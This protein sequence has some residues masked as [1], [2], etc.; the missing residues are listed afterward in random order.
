MSEIKT[1]NAMLNPLYRYAGGRRD[2]ELE[3]SVVRTLIG[4]ALAFYF[5]HHSSF[6]LHSTLHLSANFKLVIIL[7]LSVAV[8]I[9][10]C[11]ALYPGDVPLRRLIA[12]FVDV[13]TL[14]Y[15]F[16]QAE[17][18][19]APLYFFYLWIII[20]YGFRFGKKY[21]FIS[22]AMSL[23][24]YGLVILTIPYWLMQ[25]SLSLGLWV[26]MLLISLYL[27]TLVGRLYKALDHAEVANRAKRQFISSVS[28]EL[29]TPL[30]AIIGMVDLLKSTGVDREQQDML[31][32]MSTTSQVMLSQI[33]DVL[34]FSKIEAGKMAVEQ[35]DFDLHRLVLGTVDIFRYHVDPLAIEFLISIA[36]DVPYSLRGDPHH[37][38]QILVNLLANAVKFTEQGRI[39]IRI[40]K[41]DHTESGVRL[42]FA[43]KDTGVG[44]PL[45]AQS[46]IF[47]S[48]TQADESTARRYGGTGLGTTICK[49][50]VE[51]M[52]G[53]IGFSSEQGAGSEF[54]FELEMNL[55]P[56]STQDTLS[57]KPRA[58]RSL[59]IGADSKCMPLVADLLEHCCAPVQLEED[60]NAALSKLEQTFLSGK[61]VR[62][63]F[64]N[65]SFPQTEGEM[66]E[67]REKLRA[68]VLASRAAASD[69]P[70]SLILLVPEGIAEEVADELAE[71]AGFS[72][73]LPLPIDRPSLQNILHSHALMLDADVANKAVSVPA[74]DLNSLGAI[75]LKRRSDLSSYHIL[76]AEDNP[77]NR[78]VLQKIL[79]RA[80]HRCTL[81]KDGEEA[82]D[83]IEKKE[84]DAIVLDMN[85]PVMTGLE[86]ARTYCIMR[87]PLTRAPMIMF[88]ANVTLEA[89]EES[90]NAGVDEFMPKPIQIE[91]FI[92]TLDRLV[93]HYKSSSYLLPEKP[94]LPKKRRLK[95]LFSEEPNL[96]VQTLDDL[97]KIS[98]DPHFLDDLILEFIAENRKIMIRFE[99]AL[100]HLKF[101][102]IKEI[103]HALKGSAVSIGAVSLKMLCKRIEKMTK[104]DQEIY[105]SEILQAIKQVCYV[106]CEELEAYRQQRNQYLSEKI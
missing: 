54:W 86:V 22:L 41:L 89:K 87:G 101:E 93:S 14:T 98:R 39:T 6:H 82:L 36:C 77:T 51:L 59:M 49:Q 21:L 12:I 81:A 103:L 15:L 10:V 4:I 27:S 53:Q 58:I 83:L 72:S 88:S 33:E 84:F 1:K 104:I 19:A 8:A 32:C 67:F 57:A 69:V 52:H 20:G 78:K 46:R 75:N 50:L 74:P 11:V 28:H 48:F 63:I 90:L 61:P 26:G 65:I 102:E 29:R 35:T 106:L 96:T 73:L 105:S 99:S 38:R 24:G 13:G 79:E 91:L 45:D 95:L 66:Q 5:L 42:H 62:L 80:G 30:N 40:R 94:G 92:N 100:L 7:F 56:P 23:A 76:V 16:I 70:L 64:L 34:D 43:V 37:L 71:S 31:D 97:E 25:P 17:D 60:L 18:Y 2:S 55:S 3:Q 85:M 68:I 47:D 9:S 44:I